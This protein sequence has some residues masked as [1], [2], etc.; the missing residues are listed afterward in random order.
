V[1]TITSLFQKQTIYTVKK[2]NKKGKKMLLEKEVKRLSVYEN[3][4][5]NKS[6]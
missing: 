5:K 3:S 1:S 6:K 2:L 4:L